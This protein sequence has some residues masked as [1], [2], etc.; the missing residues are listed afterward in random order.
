MTKNES[1][2]SAL[3]GAAGISVALYLYYRLTPD[4]KRRLEEKIVT[5]ANTILDTAKDVS[6]TLDNY[7]TDIKH[8]EI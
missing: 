6:G 8:T 3:I 7:V 5:V 2:L 4:E 1:L